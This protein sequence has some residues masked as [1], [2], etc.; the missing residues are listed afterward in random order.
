MLELRREIEATRPKT[1]ADCGAVMRPCHFLSCRFNLTLEV[2]SARS[3]QSMDLDE[4][5]EVEASCALD[6]A[7]RGGITLEEVGSLL[8]VTRERVRQIE[9]I[10]LARVRVKAEE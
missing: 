5:V 7:D 8:G 3:I 4:F 9:E 10:A 2:T 6:V 1:R